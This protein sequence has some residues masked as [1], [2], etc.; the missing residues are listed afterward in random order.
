MIRIMRRFFAVVAIAALTSWLW[1][2]LSAL[3]ASQD[4]S[5]QD[6]R[7]VSQ[8]YSPSEAQSTYRQKNF[9][10]S[11]QQPDTETAQEKPGNQAQTQA[12]QYAQ[13]TQSSRSQQYKE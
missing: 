5:S 2:P 12:K 7:Q 1:S 6:N 10:S 11:D 9:S 8:S 4:Y 13:Q 3:A